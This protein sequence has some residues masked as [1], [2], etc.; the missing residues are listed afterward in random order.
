VALKAIFFDQDG[1]IIDTERDGHRVAFNQAF[2]EFGFPFQWDVEEYHSLLQVGGGKERMKHYLHTQGFGVAVTPQAENDLIKELHLR[3]TALFI[4][5]IESGRLPLRPGVHRLMKEAVDHGLILGI[6]TTSDEKAART[7]V[8]KILADIPFSFILAG[9]VVKK[10]KPDPEIYRLALQ[11]TGLAPRQCLVVEDSANGIRAA[12]SA[13]IPVLATSNSYTEREDLGAADMVVTCLGDFQGDKG[14]LR[15][16]GQD[17]NYDG[18]LTLNQLVAWHR[19]LLDAL[20]NEP[21]RT[22]R[23]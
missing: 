9:D 6:C 5:L 17:L 8:G 7:I 12:K 16:G 23:T 4:E 13:G 10:K 18:I 21:Q 22:Q 1:V 2:R 15:H 14:I 19:T 11:K 20:K 3:K